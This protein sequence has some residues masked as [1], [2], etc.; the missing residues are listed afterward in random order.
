MRSRVRNVLLVLLG[1][2]ALVSKAH[3]TGPFADLVHRYGGNATGSFAAYFV[4]RIVTSGWRQ[5]RLLTAGVVFLFAGLFEA[6]NG[7]GVMTNVYDPV[8]FAGNGLG[9][10]V[11]VVVD[12]LASPRRGPP[13]AGGTR[14]S[15]GTR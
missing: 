9:V 8:D 10:A 13:P 6:T 12:T 1:V 3:Y 14:S 5:G 7:F 15:E 4:I 2:A 11:A